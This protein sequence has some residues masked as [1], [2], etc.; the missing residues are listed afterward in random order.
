LSHGSQGQL[1]L[2]Q[3]IARNYGKTLGR[4]IS[5]E[6]EV[7]ITVGA[8]EA[9]FLAF[10]AFLNEGDEVI[11]IEPAFDIYRGAAA[12]C[13]AIVRSVWTSSEPV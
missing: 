1:N 7:A 6:Q 2:C 8:T 4:T 5:A 12:M 13:G 11:M 9:L 10:H 3:S